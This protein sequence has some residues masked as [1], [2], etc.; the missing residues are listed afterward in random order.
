MPFHLGKLLLSADNSS[1]L[2]VIQG[3]ADVKAGLSEDSLRKTI[4]F[5]TQAFEPASLEDWHKDGDNSVAKEGEISEEA[6]AMAAKRMADVIAA[7]KTLRAEDMFHIGKFVSDRFNGL[8]IRLE[9]GALGL[10]A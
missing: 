7:K 6:K 8:C 1:P 3:D 4:D 2:T 10:A 9:K 5:C